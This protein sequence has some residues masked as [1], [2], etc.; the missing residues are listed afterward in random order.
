MKPTLTCLACAAALL[1]TALTAQAAEADLSARI[2]SLENQLRQLQARQQAQAETSGATVFSG[3]GEINYNRPTARGADTV[4]DVSRFV[5]GMQHRF[6]ARTKVV[7]ELEVEHAVSSADDSGEVEVEQAF[8]EHQLNDTWTARAGLF[9]IPLGLLNENHEPTVRHGV[10]RN[11]VETAIIPTTWREGGVRL[12]GNFDSGL[13]WDVGVSTGFDLSKWD[14]TA[15][16]GV[17]T[18]LGSVHQ[19][20]SLAKAR[21]LSVFTALNWRGVPGLQLGGGLF[22]G[23]ATQGQT[24]TQARVTLWEVHARWTPGDWDVS[25]LYAGGSI[26]GTAA[27]NTTFVGGTLIPKRFDGRNV[28]VAYTAWRSGERALTPFARVDW[29]NTGRSYAYAGTGVTPEARS[30][31]RQLTLGVDWRLTSGVVLK[32]DWQRLSSTNSDVVAGNQVNLGLGWS[33]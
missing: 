9:L 13:S 7:T 2:E 24:S 5:L 17:E 12:T 4:F 15:S 21:D 23:G 30:T 11:R 8:V 25:A 19:E 18:P 32:A 27:L 33:F 26:S 3:Y 14:A 20:L 6:D 28:Q 22:T 31:D 10:E 1:S 29:V 16:E